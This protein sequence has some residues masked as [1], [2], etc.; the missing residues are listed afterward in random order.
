LAVTTPNPEGA[1]KTERLAWS[2]GVRA[3]LLLAFVAITGFA[4]LAAAGAIYAFREVGSRLDVVDAR[5]PPALS[6][7]ELSRSAERIIAA[8]PALLAATDRA[9]RDEVKAELAAEVERLNARLAELIGAGA[10]LL[11]LS[12]IEPTV[13]SLTANLARLEALVARRLEASEHVAALRRGVFQTNEETQRLLAPWLEILGGEIAALVEAREAGPTSAG[14]EPERL[15]SALELQRL[16]RTAQAR[17]STVADMLTE[18]STA[19]QPRRLEVLAFQLGLALGELEATAAG[20]DPRLRP[21]FEEQA[22]KL[23]AFAEGPSAVAEA[24]EQELALVGK[25]NELLTDTAG[26][27]AELTAAVDRLGSAAKQEIGQAIGDALS[28]QRLSTRALVIVVALSLLTSVLIVWL[29]V[30]GNIVRRLTALSDGMLAIAGGRLHSPVPVDGGDEIAAMGGA[31][32]IFRRNTLERD[33]L[34]VE[35]AQAAEVLEKEVKQRTA[36]LSEALEQQTA[37]AEILRAISTSPTDAQPVFETIVQNA[38]ALSGSLFANVFRFDGELLHFLASHNV[39]PSYVG[40]LQAKYPMRPDASQISGRVLLTKSVVWLEDALADPDYDQRF[41]SALG[42]RRMLGVPMLREGRALGVIVVG[43]AEPGA[44]SRVQEELLKTFAD[45]AVIAIE[46]VRM[47]EDIQARTRE[48]NEALQQQT[49]TADVLKI[50][51]RSTFDLQRVLETLVAS[52]AQLCEADAAAMA[53][54]QGGF[55][56]QV[57]HYGT[58]PEY[59]DFVKTLPLSPGRGSLVGRVLLEG[60]T[61]QIPDVLADPEYTMQDMQKRAGF[62]TLLGVPLLRGG[63]PVG[64]FVLWHCTVK[65]FTAKQIDLVTTFADQ[66]VIAIE[67]A[68]LF[69]EIQEKSRQLEVANKYKS[70]FLAS[71]SHDLRQP[72]HALNLFVAQLRTESDPEERN[73]L[74]ARINAAVSSMNELFEALLDMSKLDAGVLET[75]LIEFP[76]EPLLKR[77]ETT[78]AEAAR[79]KGLRLAV[80][81]SSAWVRSDFILLERILLNLVSNAVRYTTKGGVVVG[82]RR[83]DG[84][85]RIDICDNGSGIPEEQQRTIFG[86]FVQLTTAKLDRRGGLGLGLA[87]V[88]RLGRLLEHPIEV[89]SRVGRGSRFSIIVP[90]VAARSEAT[91]APVTFATIADS[92]RGKRIV[93]IDD[94]PLVID[95][96]GGILRSWGCEV[97]TAESGETALAKLAAQRLK[98]DLIISDYRLANGKTGIEAVE[99]LRDE[100]GAAIPAFLISGD[101][102]PERLREASASGYH[103]L[104]K[105]VAPMRLRAMLSQLVKARDAPE[106]SAPAA[107]PQPIRR[108]A[109]VPG[110]AP[111]LR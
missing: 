75:N 90:L 36:E 37:T 69:D 25:G 89:N 92:A 85:V 76:I 95:G 99:R 9:R 47:F 54:E 12:E 107:R 71:A 19:D 26:L 72:L 23:R 18:A 48:L 87:I 33:A 109:A 98:P 93:V 1:Q 59:N 80:V 56:Y 6:A 57:A 64:V 70:H 60:R 110:P 42:W 45:Q 62:R 108:P 38:V 53:R 58:P 103:L 24:R 106:T 86:E 94:D 28:V 43:L 79:E 73:R 8:A 101:T 21:L 27:S 105:P 46:N 13:S 15:A 81:P 52:A 35:K 17:V 50:I 83:R 77:I 49:A 41:P 14:D 7:L 74:V 67:N 44:V 31:V 29:Y 51:S 16:V 78:F 40:L 65:P 91:E 63:N 5:L 22:A 30:G 104:H 96:M 39:G 111:R 97:V 55:H 100:L 11:P 102:A 82:C 2:L 88:D 3:R 32:E 4:V 68:R 61:I 20:L 10:A 34:L 66:A 84:Q